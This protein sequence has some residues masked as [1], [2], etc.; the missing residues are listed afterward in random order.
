MDHIAAWRRFAHLRYADLPED[1]RTVANQCVLDWFAC[2]LAGSAEPLAHILRDEFSHRQ[3]R[4]TLIGTEQTTDAATAALLNGAAALGP[5]SAD[6]QRRSSLQPRRTG[7]QAA[8]QVRYL[9][10]GR[11]SGRLG[12]S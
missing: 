8:P 7:G 12:D 3:G 4:C 1:V 11:P 10:W 5:R 9:A 2:A 6:R